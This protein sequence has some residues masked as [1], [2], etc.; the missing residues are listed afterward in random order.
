MKAQALRGDSTCSNR[1]QKLLL[2]VCSYFRL[3]S[4]RAMEQR[5]FCGVTISNQNTEMARRYNISREL[6]GCLLAYCQQRRDQSQSIRS[7]RWYICIYIYIQQKVGQNN[8][9][10]YRR[11]QRNGAVSDRYRRAVSD[12]YEIPGA[13]PAKWHPLTKLFSFADIVI[14]IV[15][16][17]WRATQPSPFTLSLSLSCSSFHRTPASVP[18]GKAE[19]AAAYA[20]CKCQQYKGTIAFA[21]YRQSCHEDLRIRRMTFITCMK[22]AIRAKV[23]NTGTELVYSQQAYMWITEEMPSYRFKE[24]LAFESKLYRLENVVSNQSLKF[25]QSFCKIQEF[26]TLQ[27]QRYMPVNFYNFTQR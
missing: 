11:R 6:S 12:G 26:F 16:L 17:R 3:I 15:C 27:L 25:L 10:Q 20:V 7:K 23:F 24:V 2:T 19:G 18:L 14:L 13:A 22:R 21:R 1:N 5:Q 4:E 8:I 9:A